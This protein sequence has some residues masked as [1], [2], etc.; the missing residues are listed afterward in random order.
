MRG[1]HGGA[2][3]DLSVLTL[4]FQIFIYGGI[5]ITTTIIIIIINHPHVMPPTVSDPERHDG[6]RSCIRRRTIDG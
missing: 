1:G 3:G 4:L 6:G 5:I 2:A